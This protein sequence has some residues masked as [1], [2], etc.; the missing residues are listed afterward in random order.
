M[1]RIKIDDYFIDEFNLD[2]NQKNNN[3]ISN[4]PLSEIWVNYRKNY[5]PLNPQSVN[6]NRPKHLKYTLNENLIF[7]FYELDENFID[8]KNQ[9]DLYISISND[10]NNYTN[11]FLTKS[12]LVSL[13][14]VFLLPKYVLKN[15]INFQNKWTQN[16]KNF[17]NQQQNITDIKN[18]YKTRTEKFNLLIS[19]NKAVYKDYI[20]LNWYN[21][22]N[23]MLNIKNLFEWVGDT[24][25]YKLHFDKKIIS[26]DDNTHNDD[27]INFHILDSLATKYTQYE[28]Q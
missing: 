13:G 2:F 6:I 8:K 9:H 26:F 27:G 1:I 5:D 23:N 4:M 24:G 11:G 3:V 21:I 25:Y 22:K 19:N 14:V 17:R 18:F 10:D 20:G 15:F 12:T 16:N 7:R 28:N